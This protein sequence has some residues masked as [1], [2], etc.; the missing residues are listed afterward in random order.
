MRSATAEPIGNASTEDADAEDQHAVEQEDQTD[1]HVEFVVG[2]QRQERDVPAE[3]DQAEEEHDAGQQCRAVDEPCVRLRVRIARD[4]P[5]EQR[6]DARRERERGRDRPREAVAIV[7]GDEVAERRTER[8]AAVYRDRPVAHRLAAALDR[9]EVGD[10]RRGPDEERRLADP[11]DDPGD[12]EPPQLVDDA[13]QHSRERDDQR[14]RRRSGR[15]VRPGRRCGRR[16]CA[17]SPRRTRTR[18]RRRRPRSCPG[19]V[20]PPRSAG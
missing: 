3:R 2:V 18:R 8:E 17:G 1:V 9:R 13:V 20:R 12:D 15:G 6:E 11:G 5:R 19:R 14:A 4:V 10:H 16:R 7:T